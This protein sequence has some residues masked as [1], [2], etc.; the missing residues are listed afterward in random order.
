MALGTDLKMILET[1]D[2]IHES[3]YSAIERETNEIKNLIK[4]QNG[5]VRDLEVGAAK[6]K[7]Y[8]TLAVPGVLLIFFI[9]YVA[10]EAAGLGILIKAIF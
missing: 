3:R 7:A 8:W 5:R 6:R 4:A 2:K 1:Y 9:L 10:A